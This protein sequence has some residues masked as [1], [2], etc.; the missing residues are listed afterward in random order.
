[1]L[2]AILCK[3]NSTIRL[4]A[5]GDYNELQDKIDIYCR[6]LSDFDVKL[7]NVTGLDENKLKNDLELVNKAFEKEFD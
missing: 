4:I 1:M 6:I 7:L 5:I 3:S 2:G